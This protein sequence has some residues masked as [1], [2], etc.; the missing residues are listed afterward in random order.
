MNFYSAAN[1]PE[2]YYQKP[3]YDFF[4]RIVHSNAYK[5]LNPLRTRFDTHD[6]DMFTQIP[7][8][9]GKVPMHSWVYGH[10]DYSYDKY[11]RHYQ[12]HDEW[13]PDRKNKSLGFKEGG[14]CDPSLRHP[15]YIVLDNEEHPRG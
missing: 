9:L 4:N 15:K 13:Y 12:T 1:I 6:P 2:Y 5:K 8:F 11:H 7:T 3:H 14:F 10:L